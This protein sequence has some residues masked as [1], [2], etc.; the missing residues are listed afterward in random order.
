MTYQEYMEKYDYCFGHSQ[1]E[2]GE[3]MVS[4]LEDLLAELRD[5]GYPCPDFVEGGIPVKIVLDARNQ[6]ERIEEVLW[7]DDFA[8]EDYELTAEGKEFLMKCFEEYNEKYANYGNYCDTV[9]VQVPDE[10]KYELTDDEIE[11]E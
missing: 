7:D 8:G 6:V 1:Y 4:K 9:T 3:S 5:Y 10:L 2:D 11:A